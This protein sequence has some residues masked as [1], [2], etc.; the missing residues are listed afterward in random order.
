MTIDRFVLIDSPRS[1]SWELRSLPRFDV[2]WRVVAAGV[3][4]DSL[5]AAKRLLGCDSYELTSK[6]EPWR[7]IG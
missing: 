5:A 3:G 7:R 2:S 4:A 1:E 6:L